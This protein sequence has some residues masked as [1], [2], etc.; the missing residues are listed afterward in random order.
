MLKFLLNTQKNGKHIA[1]PQTVFRLFF[2]Y[3]TL[4]L[5][6]VIHLADFRLLNYSENN[7]RLF[8]S[9][10]FI[11]S[12]Q[13]HYMFGKC[14]LNGQKADC[15]NNCFFREFYIMSNEFTSGQVLSSRNYC[16]FFFCGSPSQ[17]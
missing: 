10:K 16:F 1:L 6:K 8:I 13:T 12:R 3:V 11:F 4:K 14:C 7:S 15:K 2:C 9:R 5:Q 17:M